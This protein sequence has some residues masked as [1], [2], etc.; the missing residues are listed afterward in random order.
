MRKVIVTFL[1]GLI[2]LGGNCTKNP[3][4]P[5]VGQGPFLYAVSDRYPDG[6]TRVYVIDTAIDSLIDT[7]FVAGLGDVGLSYGVSPDG[8]KLYLNGGVLDTRNRTLI[9][10][11]VSGVPTPDGKYL[12]LGS[13]AANIFGVVDARTNQIV[14]NTDSLGMIVTGRGREYDYIGGLVYGRMQDSLYNVPTLIGVFDYRKLDFVKIIRPAD[15]GG[16]AIA[17]NDIVVTK[18]G[19]KLYYTSGRSGA[20][21][22]ID[23]IRDT[24]ITVLG[25]NSISFLGVR[26]DDNYIYLTDPGGYFIEPEPTEKIGVYSPLLESPLQSIDV[27]SIPSPCTLSG[28]ATEMIALSPDGG[29]AY[30]SIF[31]FCGIIVIDTW[32]NQVEKVIQAEIS[33]RSL[34]IL[35]PYSNTFFKGG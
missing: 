27:S 13:I 19:R 24:V 21:T 35:K 10:G 30:V 28:L 22:G 17:V 4:G 26:P 33:I 2:L 1:L 12:L 11:A 34:A 5:V 31:D 3:T 16:Y 14:Y 6:Y 8:S 9:S 15:I 23:L 7:I 20:F 29:K 18:D 25:L 32:S